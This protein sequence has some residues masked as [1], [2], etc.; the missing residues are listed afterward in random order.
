MPIEGGAI[1]LL[2][3]ASI[4]ANNIDQFKEFCDELYGLTANHIPV[5]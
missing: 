4:H 5:H 3:E 1:V 2:H